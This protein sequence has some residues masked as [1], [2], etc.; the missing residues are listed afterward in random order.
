[1]KFWKWLA[2]IC[3]A[4]FIALLVFSWLA[5]GQRGGPDAASQSEPPPA[6]VFR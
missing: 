4:L 6:P 5:H 3:S 1:M 2:R